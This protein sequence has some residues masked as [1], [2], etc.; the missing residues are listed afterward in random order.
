MVGTLLNLRKLTTTSPSAP[1]TPEHL[2]RPVRAESRLSRL[3]SAVGAPLKGSPETFDG[4]SATLTDRSIGS[5]RPW[6]QFRRQ[7]KSFSSA[8]ASLFPLSPP[9][10]P[11]HTSSGASPAFISGMRPRFASER[12]KKQRHRDDGLKHRISYP[13]L[14]RES[15]ENQAGRETWG[16][17]DETQKAPTPT[18]TAA[19]SVSRC[20]SKREIRPRLHELG[21]R[22]PAAAPESTQTRST[23]SPLYP[24]PLD[25]TPVRGW[26]PSSLRR[27]SVSTAGSVDSTVTESSFAWVDF[28]S[29][30]TMTIPI[31]STERPT[32]LVARTTADAEGAPGEPAVSSLGLNSDPDPFRRSYDANDV[33]TA[34]SGSAM[35]PFPPSTITRA[36]RNPDGP[37]PGVAK[38]MLFWTSKDVAASDTLPA[39]PRALPPFRGEHLW[40]PQS[41]PRI[42]PTCS[43]QAK[44]DSKPAWSYETKFT[45]N[46]EA[47]PDSATTRVSLLSLTLAELSDEMAALSRT[48]TTER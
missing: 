44:N 27:S 47:E 22:T 5:G 13:L 4:S 30:M 12:R 1:P 34:R 15:L 31:P 10:T 41:T 28:P 40:T 43:N 46:G 24:C 25:I 38:R 37:A 19:S 2:T 42:R 20:S 39:I 14:L 21:T 23:M 9:A 11:T 3:G 7:S 33:F 18:T 45:Q 8:F 29:T 35:R 26:M 16:A 17:R 36:S 32:T 6:K 48:R